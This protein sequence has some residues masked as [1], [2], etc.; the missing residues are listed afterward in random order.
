M[1]KFVFIFCSINLKCI[2]GY[3]LLL[4]YFKGFNEIQKAVVIEKDTVIK[5]NKEIVGIK[6]QSNPKDMEIV[7]KVASS[8]IIEQSEVFGILRLY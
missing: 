7:K 4:I 2:H 5:V 8:A 1:Y 6:D 3:V